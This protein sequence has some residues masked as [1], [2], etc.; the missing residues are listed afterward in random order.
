MEREIAKDGY[1]M[2]TRKERGTRMKER[3]KRDKETGKHG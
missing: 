1:A 3:Y 2:G